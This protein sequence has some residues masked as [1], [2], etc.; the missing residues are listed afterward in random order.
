[1]LPRTASSS[2][3]DGYQEQGGLVELPG[4]GL[5]KV[6]EQVIESCSEEPATSSRCGCQACTGGRSWL[7]GCRLIL[8]ER[9]KNA[10]RARELF[11]ERELE[12]W[13]W[14]PVLQ[15]QEANTEGMGSGQEP[16][17]QG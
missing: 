17:G 3:A 1:M 6:A 16:G 9:S 10:P 4:T 13:S 8:S 7:L 11:Q 5:E 15:W 12:E 2:W 14:V